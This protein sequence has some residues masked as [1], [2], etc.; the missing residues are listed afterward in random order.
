M[1]L[2]SGHRRWKKQD[3]LEWLGL[4]GEK[5]KD[6]SERVILYARVSGSNQA[7]GFRSKG[8]LDNDLGR[9]LKALRSFVKKNYK[10]CKVEEYTDVGSGI[11]FTRPKFQRMVNKILTGQYDGSTLVCS[12]RDR[13]CRLGFELVAQ[14]CFAHNI[15]IVYTDQFCLTQR[16]LRGQK[17]KR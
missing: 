3:V 13:I 4:D 8:S 6:G 5:E 14:I 9:Q 16:P 12:F 10:N 11:S 17:A 7:S 1:T 2:P 15:A